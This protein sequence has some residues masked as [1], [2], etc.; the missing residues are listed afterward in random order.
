MKRLL[1]LCLLGGLG[2]ACGS[3]GGNDPVSACNA[4]CE[5]ILS[6]EG[7]SG[8]A[9]ACGSECS[10]STLQNQLS[11]QGVTCSNWTAIFNCFASLSCSDLGLGDG[12]TNAAAE[13]SCANQGGCTFQ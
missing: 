2:V 6:C 13:T 1:L 9:S 3:S 10:G 12:G 8:L 7:Q 5:H 4:Y 11:S